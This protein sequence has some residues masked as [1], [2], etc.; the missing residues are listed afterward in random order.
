M[1]KLTD[2]DILLLVENEVDYDNPIFCTETSCPDFAECTSLVNLSEEVR[3]VIK[4][5]K[6]MTYN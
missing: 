3:P 1:G 5:I 4:K 6:R 2:Q